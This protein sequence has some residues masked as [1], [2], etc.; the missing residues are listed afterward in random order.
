MTRF[1]LDFM[2]MANECQNLSFTIHSTRLGGKRSGLK[3]NWLTSDH[4]NPEV[5]YPKQSEYQEPTEEDYIN[6]KV[7]CN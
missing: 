3:L 4:F 7:K 5:K 6:L 2:R 1:K